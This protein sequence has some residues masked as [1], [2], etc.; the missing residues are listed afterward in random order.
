MTSGTMTEVK[1]PSKWHSS[2]IERAS[3]LISEG[4]VSSE[5]LLIG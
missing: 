5:E 1:T 4:A 2:A 3:L